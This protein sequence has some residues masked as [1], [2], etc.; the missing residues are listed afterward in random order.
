[1]VASRTPS[2]L[3]ADEEIDLG[4]SREVQAS[5]LR[6]FRAP[7]SPIHTSHFFFTKGRRLRCP[8]APIA[9]AA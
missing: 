4:T 6:D 1:V 8:P 7:V 2:L 9:L 5:A 3:Q